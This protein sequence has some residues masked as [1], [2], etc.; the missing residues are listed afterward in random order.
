MREE[1]SSGASHLY[2]RNRQFNVKI[3]IQKSK[4]CSQLRGK[5]VVFSTNEGKKAKKP[6]KMC[7]NCYQTPNLNL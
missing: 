2:K 4:T 1:L 7:E 6:S 3:K 5:Q